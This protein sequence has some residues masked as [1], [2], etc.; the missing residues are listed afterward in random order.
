MTPK[1]LSKTYAP[2][3]LERF[4]EY[5]RQWTTSNS[6]LA[7]QGISPSTQGQQDFAKK[8]VNELNRLG[9][10]D[11]QITGYGYVCARIPATPGMEHVPAIGFSAHLDTSEE[12]SCPS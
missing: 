9:I 7:D 1:N 12:V 4:L 3:L 5:V 11:T 6:E 2:A 10:T 8:L